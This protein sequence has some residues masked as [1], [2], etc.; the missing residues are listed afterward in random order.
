MLQALKSS[1]ESRE[2]V[3][4][5]MK[6]LRGVKGTLVQQKRRDK[7]KQDGARQNLGATNAAVNAAVGLQRQNFSAAN[8]AANAAARVPRPVAGG[9]VQQRQG[10]LFGRGF[11]VD[12]A[13]D[14]YRPY[15]PS[16]QQ[17]VGP[18]QMQQLH[19]AVPGVWQAHAEGRFDEG[20]VEG[21][22]RGVWGRG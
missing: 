10:Q 21:A 5:A 12:G 16:Q 14:N 13:R 20:D 1:N 9:A 2:L 11:G 15:L 19:Q 3:D 17:P 6:Y 18:Q 8:A 4:V 7:E 22:L